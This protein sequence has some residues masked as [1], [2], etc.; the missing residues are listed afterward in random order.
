MLPPRPTDRFML[1]R[2]EDCGKFH[3]YPRP[4]CPH[5]QGA[6]LAWGE[7]SGKGAVYSHSTVHRAPSPEFREGVPYVIAIVKTDEGPHLLSRVVGVSPEKVSIG[8][9]LQVRLSVDGKPE[10]EPEV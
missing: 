10:F 6:K 5:C 7:A 2:C 9:R 1:P 4:V 3:F 8:M